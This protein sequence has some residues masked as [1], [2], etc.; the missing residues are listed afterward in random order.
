MQENI[1]ARHPQS[2][3]Q[4]PPVSIESIFVARSKDFG[5]VVLLSCAT[6]QLRASRCAR[7]GLPCMLYGMSTLHNTHLQPTTRRRRAG[8]LGIH[9]AVRHAPPPLRMLLHPR[10]PLQALPGNSARSSPR[11]RRW[12]E[13]S[14]QTT[15][16]APSSSAHVHTT[17]AR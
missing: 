11:S 8:R 6:L 5:A 15:A 3:A 10:V 14:D 9:H 1:G 13:A 16:Q 12:K 17:H 7:V 2:L 4:Q